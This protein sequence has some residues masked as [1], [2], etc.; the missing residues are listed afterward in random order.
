MLTQEREAKNKMREKAKELQRQKMEAAKKGIKSSFGSSA[1]FGSSSGYTPIPSVGD[2]AN[3]SN[4]VKPPSYS[5]API[6]LIITP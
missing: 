3:I 5:S 1:G 4:D 2:V 6:Q